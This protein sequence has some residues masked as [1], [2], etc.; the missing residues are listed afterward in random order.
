M[1]GGG[2]RQAIDFPQ[3]PAR[4]QL[5]EAPHGGRIRLIV[6]ARLHRLPVAAAQRRDEARGEH[7]LADVRVRTRND[8]SRPHASSLFNSSAS[9]AAIDATCASST[10]SVSDRR[11]RAVPSGTVG[12]RTARMSKPRACMAAARRVAR[13]SEPMTTGWMCEPE[14]SIPQLSASRPAANVTS[15]GELLA[16]RAV[17]PADEQRGAHHSGDERRGCRRIDERARAIDQVVAQ[18]LRPGDERSHRPQRLAAGMQGEDVGLSFEVRPEAAAHG[19]QHAGGVR[20]VDDEH[21]L[22]PARD[23]G[24]IVERRAVAVH[25]VEA[26][27]RDPRRAGAARRPPVGDGVREGCGVVMP[28]LGA[29]GLAHA[30][31]VVDRGVDKRIVH[32]EVTALRQG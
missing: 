23:L 32:D 28:C 5:G 3:H 29:L 8:D 2:R 30:Q 22:V 17:E 25:A 13:S 27:H 31:A 11:R 24:Q 19:P 21:A 12:G 18:H 16:P 20:L 10:L 7:G 1:R 6:E 15:A 14:A 4:R 26:F 9:A